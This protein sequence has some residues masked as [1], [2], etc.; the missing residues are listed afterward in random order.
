MK[1]V[2]HKNATIIC[3]QSVDPS[4]LNAMNYTK[5]DV[6]KTSDDENDLATNSTIMFYLRKHVPKMFQAA[7]SQLTESQVQLTLD[8]LCWREKY[9]PTSASCFATIMENLAF[10]TV[11]E[12]ESK[13]RCVIRNIQFLFSSNFL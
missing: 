1:Q 12:T 6:C 11:R 13:S 7:L 2:V 3:D 9:A 4:C 5:V 8:E 10:I